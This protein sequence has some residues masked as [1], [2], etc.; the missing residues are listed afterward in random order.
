[1]PRYK[2]TIEY[3]GTGFVGWQMQ[4]QGPSIQGEIARAAKA[5]SGE[6]TIPGGSGRT[7]AGVHARGQVAHLDLSKEHDP[8]TVRDALNA[9]LRPHP[10]AILAA[11]RVDDDFD[12]RFSCLGRRYEY[13]ILPRRAPPALLRHR[14][15]QVPKPLDVDA[16]H[17][18][19]L[20][21]V[22]THDFTTFRAV[23]CQSRS[24]VKTMDRVDVSRR[25]DLV[26]IQA[27]ARSFL[28]HQIRSISGALK[29]VGEGRWTAQDM[30]QALA[31]SDRAAC[32]PVAPPD[33]LYFLEARY[34]T[35]LETKPPSDSASEPKH[36]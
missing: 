10:I 22:G 23:A 1:M 26:V 12:A 19:A 15:W 31:A 33:G 7:D 28:H 36:A 30:A 16:M 24:P 34:P 20:K 35:E 17:E 32:P 2:L 11:T 8:D 21:L 9:H 4:A 27:A 6:D 13:L 18:A 3:D 29:W 5:F 14:V 25:D